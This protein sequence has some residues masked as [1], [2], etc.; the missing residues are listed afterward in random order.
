MAAIQEHLLRYRTD[1]ASAVRAVDAELLEG[2]AAR[3]GFSPP[4]QPLR[5]RPC[6]PLPSLS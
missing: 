5:R 4:S 1:P 3:N 2:A 6:C